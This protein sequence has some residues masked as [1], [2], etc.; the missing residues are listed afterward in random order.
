MKN[1]IKY[2][3]QISFFKLRNRIFRQI[4]RNPVGWALRYFLLICFF[5]IMKAMESTVKDIDI[6]HARGFVFYNYR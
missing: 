5:I 4:S 1:T 6:K 2:L 3:V